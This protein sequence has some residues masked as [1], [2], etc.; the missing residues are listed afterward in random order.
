MSSIYHHSAT[1]SAAAA[2]GIPIENGGTNRP[3]DHYRRHSPNNVEAD[4]QA[5]DRIPNGKASVIVTISA[6]GRALAND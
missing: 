3:Q 6:A 2:Y 4:K 5:Q 1:L